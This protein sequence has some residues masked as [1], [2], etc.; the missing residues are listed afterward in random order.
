MNS[1]QGNPSYKIVSLMA[2]PQ[3]DD[4][5]PDERATF[6][7]VDRKV[8]NLA[9]MSNQGVAAWSRSL[10]GID[11][12][13]L[14][15]IVQLEHRLSNEMMTRSP[16]D[17]LAPRTPDEIAVIHQ[18]KRILGF[19]EPRGHRPLRERLEDVHAALSGTRT[20]IRSSSVLSTPD[21]LGKFV[22]FPDAK[23]IE[24]AL[25][26][27]DRHIQA[28]IDV[29]RAFTATVAMTALCN[30]HPFGDGNGR[31]SR[32][33]FNALLRAPGNEGPYIPLHEL[34]RVSRA[35][36]LIAMR[37]AQYRNEWRTLADFLSEAISFVGTLD[38]KTRR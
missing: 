7:L 37:L 25:K 17:A 11:L 20:S 14:P 33:V 18:A 35:G 1:S 38:A 27:I 21:K 10:H 15:R 8:A 34:G 24:P 23:A 5:A 22:I 26:D 4:L 31:V 9:G 3:W 36:F 2:L 12:N 32:I 19:N 16:I 28:N 29:S 6:G 13:K 30:V